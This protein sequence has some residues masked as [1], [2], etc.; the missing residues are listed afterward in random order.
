MQSR[1]T[2]VPSII[3]PVLTVA[4]AA[5]LR[6]V[7]NASSTVRASRTGRPASRLSAV[8]SGSIFVYDLL[9]YPPPT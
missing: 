6:T 4:R 2:S 5:C 9:P 3:T 1:A 7:R 8:V